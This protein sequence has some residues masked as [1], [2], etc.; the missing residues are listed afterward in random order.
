MSLVGILFLASS[1]LVIAF[2]TLPL[3]ALFV[4]TIDYLPEIDASSRHTAWQALRLT[5]TTTATSLVFILLLGTPLAYLLARFQF[6]GSRLVDA[7]VD[8]PVVLPPSV[9]GLA[10]LMAFGRRGLLGEYLVDAG[11]RISFTTIAVVLAQCFVAAPFYIRTAKAGFSSF[12]LAAEEAAAVDGAS[13][14]R[15]ALDVTLPLA[16]PALSAGA[17]LAW[18]RAVGEFGATILFA[19]N[20]PGRTR[21]MPLAIYSHYESG[22]LPTALAMSSILLVVSFVVLIL[23]RVFVKSRDYSADG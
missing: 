15:V 21:T 3:V 7:L 22:D 10:L 20:F 1:A 18:T 14:A 4:R 8:V 17:V 19:G 16:L 9:A 12:H 5:L 6:R 2:F 13:R 11:I 23:V